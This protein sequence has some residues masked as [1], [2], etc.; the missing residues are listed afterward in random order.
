[1]YKDFDA[2]NKQK[3]SIEKDTY[4]PF[5]DIREIWWCKM[6]INIGFEQ[7]GKG[8][9]FERPVLVLKKFNQFCAL[10][11]PLTT[12][13]KKGQ[14]YF[15]LGK[16]TGASASLVLSQVRFLDSRRLSQKICVVPGELFKNIQT[17]IRDLIL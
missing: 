1:M 8:K 11:V 10:C 5:F 14:Y 12:K 16:I 9:S 13:K 2:W 3:K 15:L 4:I 7:N 6:G 17:K